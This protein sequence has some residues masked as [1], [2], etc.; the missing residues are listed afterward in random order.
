MRYSFYVVTYKI[1]N[2]QTISVAA[3]NTRETFTNAKLQEL[4]A[5]EI[6]MDNIWQAEVYEILDYNVIKQNLDF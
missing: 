1:K 5:T 2:Y 6:D 3:I 4:D